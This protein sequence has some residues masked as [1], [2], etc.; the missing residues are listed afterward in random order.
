VLERVRIDKWLWAARFF[1]TRG[2]ATEAVLGGRVRVNGRRVKPAKEIAVGDSV[3]VT[4][5]EL[6]WTL[7]VRVVADKR[8]PA[9]VA[10][11]LYEET[12]SHAPGASSAPPSAGSPGRRGPTSEHDRPSR[13]AA[14]WRRFAEGTGAEADRTVE[15][16][17]RAASDAPGAAVAHLAARSRHGRQPLRL[18]RSRLPRPLREAPR[19]F[20]GRSRSHMRGFVIDG[21]AIEI[22]L[23]K[24]STVVAL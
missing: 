11:T 19:P 8:C 22:F 12:P 9:A 13:R 21:V 20:D 15:R 10:S 18:V 7:V 16:V 1:K 14:S 3:E 5:G 6:R 23:F 24:R 17:G 2:A 4:I